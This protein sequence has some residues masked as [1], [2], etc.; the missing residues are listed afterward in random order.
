MIQRCEPLKELKTIL[1]VDDDE[2]TNFLNRFFVKQLDS[3]LEVATATNG[4]EAIAYIDSHKANGLTPCLVILDTNMPIMDGWKFLEQFGQ[5]FDEQLKKDIVIIM[6]TALE[7]QD[8]IKEAMANPNVNDTVQKPLSD[9]KLRVL[10][11]KHFVSKKD[12]GR[13]G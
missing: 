7:T 6:V 5:K 11:D 9:M 1:L 2:T 3:R 12:S 10:I 8:S 4:E 13:K